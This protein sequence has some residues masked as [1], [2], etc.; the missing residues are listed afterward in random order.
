MPAVFRID[1]LFGADV[2][3]IRV[4]ILDDGRGVEILAEGVV[5]GP[6]IIEAHKQIYDERH[7]ELQQYQIVDKS[8]CT[9]Y[10]VTALD[11]EAIA[12]QDRKA[13]II[14]PGI[15]IAV[16]ES[17]SLQFSLTE[18]WRAHLADCRFRTRS[19]RDRESALVWITENIEQP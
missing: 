12:E 1:Q 8:R 4:N 5:R 16:I 17:R 10:D 14:N 2:L 7:L 6:D 18:L 13:S 19:F 11:I 9:E 3:A 15:V